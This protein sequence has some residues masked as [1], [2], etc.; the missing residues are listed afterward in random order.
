MALNWRKRLDTILEKLR[1]KPLSLAEKCRIQFGAAVVFSLILALWVPYFWMGKLTEKNALDSGRAVA[2]SIF[3]Q[4][5]RLPAHGQIL[6]M[7]VRPAR[8][9]RR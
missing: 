2:Q 3:E 7:I 4:H 9:C 6:P 1:L 8:A 5:F